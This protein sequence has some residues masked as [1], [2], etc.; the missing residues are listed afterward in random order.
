MLTPRLAIEWR[1][2]DSKTTARS[3]T[4][5]FSQKSPGRPVSTEPGN[6]AQ[7]GVCEDAAARAGIRSERL[8]GS[9]LA[10][11]SKQG[12]VEWHRIQPRTTFSL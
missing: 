7:G 5:W 3:S 12:E 1:D 10:G 2:L 6:N 9:I 4:N 11:Q 8:A